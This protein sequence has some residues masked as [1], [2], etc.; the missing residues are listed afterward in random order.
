[1]F[2]NFNT[3][4]FHEQI[5]Y[6]KIFGRRRLIFGLSKK[7]IRSDGGPPCPTDR[8]VLFLCYV[9]VTICIADFSH[10]YI[11]VVYLSV[12]FLD[13]LPLPLPDPFA[14]ALA[15]SGGVACEQWS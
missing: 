9:D 3:E 12:F 10:L 8:C 1:M 11:F 6:Q 15:Q 7:T 5:S 4:S 14:P 2:K 13:N